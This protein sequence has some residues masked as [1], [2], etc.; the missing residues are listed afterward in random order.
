MTPDLIEPTVPNR[1]LDIAGSRTQKLLPIFEKSIPSDLRVLDG[2]VVEFAQAIDGTTCWGDVEGICLAVREALANA[3]I[4]GNESNPE[5]TVEISVGVNQNHDLLI[6]FKDSGA[7]FD[8]N[9]IANPTAQ[10]NLLAIH[11]GGYSSFSSACT[12]LTSSSTAGH[13]FT[14]AGCASGSGSEPRSARFGLGRG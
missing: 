14:C 11:A 5:K 6:I 10:E 8:S 7:G 1:T 3:I 9:G 13:R 4:H 2:A 12:K